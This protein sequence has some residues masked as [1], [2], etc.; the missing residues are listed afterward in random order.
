MNNE[1]NDSLRALGERLRELR[2]S[3]GLK[4]R[5]LAAAAEVSTGLLSQLERGVG[6]PSYLTLGKLAATLNVPPGSFFEANANG[7]P[8]LVRRAQRKRLTPA[9]RNV[10]FDLVTPDLRGKL[11]V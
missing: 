3:R 6:N 11:E 8:F 1:T 10:T 9:S 7:D 5:D 4:L 2:R